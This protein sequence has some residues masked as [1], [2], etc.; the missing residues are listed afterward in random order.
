MSPPW[1][2][3][4][5]CAVSDC[6]VPVRYRAVLVQPLDAPSL[7]LSLL[8]SSLLFGAFSLLK[9]DLNYLVWRMSAKTF[10]YT[11]THTYTHNNHYYYLVTSFALI[12][13]N[14]TLIN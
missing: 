5:S 10:T 13:H 1:N 7:L 9:I 3:F 8:L 14:V 4:D 11:H 6:D 12:L 2:P